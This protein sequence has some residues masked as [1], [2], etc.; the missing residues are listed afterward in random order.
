MGFLFNET[1]LNPSED[2]G[3]AM[4]NW[5]G[6]NSANSSMLTVLNCPCIASIL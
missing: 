5:R 3:F 6:E 4:Y 1:T 2:R